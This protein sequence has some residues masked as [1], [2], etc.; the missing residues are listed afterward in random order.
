MRLLVCGGAG[1]IGSN[2]IRHMLETHPSIFIVNFDK[3]TY[4]GNLENLSDLAH[5]ARYRFVQGDITDL[6]ALNRTIQEHNLTHVIN[7]AAETHVDRSIHGGCKDFVLTNVLGVQMLLDAV[8]VNKLEKFVNVS[9]DEVYGS[10]NLDESTYFTED[11][12]ITPNMPYAAAKAG[13]DLMCRAYHKTH[14]LPVVVTHCSNNY[15]PYQFPEKLIPF[16]IFKLLKGEKVPV[17]GDGRNVRDWIHV[18]D[19]ARALDLLLQKG[20]PGEVYNIGV[21]NERNN[22]ELTQMILEIMGFGPERMEF[23]TDRPGHDRR[24]AIDAKKIEALGWKPIYTRDEF[25][26]GMQ[27]TIDWYRTHTGWVEQLWAKKRNEMNQFQQTL[28]GGQTPAN[29]SVP[30]AIKTNVDQSSASSLMAAIANTTPSVSAPLTSGVL[31]IGGGFLGQRLAKLIPNSIVSRVR[32]DDKAAIAAEITRY[33]PRAVINATGKTGQPNVDW[34]ET[35]Q[36]ETYQVNT[37]GA[38]MLADVCQEQGVYLVHLASGCIFYGPSP[39]MN[40]WKEEDATNPQAFY[41]RTKYAADLILSRLPKVAV[42]RLRLPIDSE[43]SPKNLIDKLASYQQV[44]D[45]QNSVTVVKDLAQVIEQLIQKQGTGIFHATNPGALRYRDLLNLYREL[46]NPEHRCEWIDEDTLA[47]RGL[48]AKTRST[49]LLQ[50]TRLAELGIQMRPIEIALRETMEQYAAHK[51]QAEP[52]APASP[53]STPTQIRVSSPGTISLSSAKPT[54]RMKG[55]IVAGGRGTRLAP[56]TNITSKQLL[57]IHNKP[58]VLYPL[59]TL[60]SSGVRD[61]LIVTG[62]EYPHHFVKL[63]GSGANYGCRISYRIQDEAGGIAQVVGMAEDFVGDDNVAVILGDNIFEDTFPQE[64]SQ[65]TEGALAFYK[66]VSD[67]Q[68][69]G[70]M[71]IDPSGRVLS[72]EEKPK[73]PK[74]NFAQV[75]LYVYDSSVFDVVRTLKPSTRGELEITDVNNAF[76]A[77]G[78]LK[79]APIQGFWSDAGTFDSLK[80]A[81]DFF[82]SRDGGM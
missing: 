81:T 4:A 63:L 64:L 54:R 60:L 6:E 47:K 45:V 59:Q 65:F 70:V 66:P 26:R 15:G 78:K 77:T 74:S 38:L 53:A 82:S 36:V 32:L 61:I 55:L 46:V 79:A 49:C 31:I 51:R 43:P 50:S 8:R 5:D 58:M 37:V 75:G 18:R 67:A 20:Q 21:D 42:V 14:G 34:C 24:Y 52:K 7:F 12:P 23:I 17:Y 16:F 19:H 69:F 28:N 72:I 71:E 1:F 27:E 2:F 76:L 40:G 33:S 13:G 41:S 44:L 48:A 9:T 80:R 3:L 73:Q 62:P 35:H 56:L 39:D 30:G 22:L 68:R 57:P 11:T 25:R 10:L 29:V